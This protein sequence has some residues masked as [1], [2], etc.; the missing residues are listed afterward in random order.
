MWMAYVQEI[1][2]VD[3]TSGIQHLHQTFTNLSFDAYHEANYG[4]GRFYTMEE[5]IRLGE[6]YDNGEEA[7]TNYLDGKIDLIEFG[8]QLQNAG[9]GDYLYHIKEHL[10]EDIRLYFCPP[11]DDDKDN[12]VQETEGDNGQTDDNKDNE[13]QETDGDNDQNNK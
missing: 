13:V 5:C 10:P 4:M 1:P 12:E 8:H 9:L 2:V 11:S 7:C 3:L 6:K